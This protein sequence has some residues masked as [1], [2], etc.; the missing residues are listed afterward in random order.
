M[1]NITS[2]HLRHKDLVKQFVWMT[3]K[4]DNSS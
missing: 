1:M 2:R 3:F 4:L